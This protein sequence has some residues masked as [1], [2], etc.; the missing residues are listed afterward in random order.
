MIETPLATA[1][2]TVE[3]ARDAAAEHFEELAEAVRSRP[4]RWPRV[5]GLVVAAGTVAVVI[6]V[7]RRNLA[8]RARERDI[9]AGFPRTIDEAI[10]AEHDAIAQHRPVVTPGA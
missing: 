8:E 10:E 1:V 5:L 6:V 2:D 3:H 7:V 4:R 9:A